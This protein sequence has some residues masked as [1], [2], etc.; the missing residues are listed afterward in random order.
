V[1]DATD[2]L[3]DIVSSLS[4]IPAPV[5]RIVVAIVKA[6]ANSPDPLRAA[7]RAASA[8]ASEEASEG[9]LRRLLGTVRKA[10]K[11]AP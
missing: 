1:S 8:A 3:G 7:K 9:V 2:A 6:I 11:R 5:I 4:K 10:G